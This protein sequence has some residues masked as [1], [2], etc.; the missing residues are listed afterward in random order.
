MENTIKEYYIKILDLYN[1]CVNMLTA[2][3]Q[4]LS[5]SS[6]QVVVNISDGTGSSSTMKI[7]SFIY[8]ENKLEELQGNFENFFDIPKSGD[9]W[10]ENDSNM[11]KFK[12]V[13]ANIAPQTPTISTDNLVSSFT[14]NNYF[15][16]L[17][18]PKM[19]LKMNVQNLTNNIEEIFVKKYIFYN[20]SLYN[21][22]KN[23]NSKTNEEYSAILYSFKKGIDY[24]V[25]DSTVQLPL[26]KEVYNSN[27]KIT[28]I[29][30][31]EGQNPWIQSTDGNDYANYQLTLNTLEYYN[32]EDSSIR[33]ILKPGDYIC[34]NDT[35][36]QYR[37]KSVNTTTNQVIIEERIGHTSLQTYDEN[38]TMFFTIYS[39]NF[40]EY[41]Y[42]QVP[43]EENQYI[44][45][46]IG[47]IYNNI[48]S[49]LSE[50]V[51]L[52]MKE[53]HM[54]DENG[55]S[56]LDENG[57]PINYIDYYNAY[58]KNIGDILTGFS[59]VSNPLLSEFDYTF[60]NN[61]QTDDS[62]KEL[63]NNTF[64]NNDILQVVPINKH[65]IDDTTSQEIISMHNQKSELNNKLTSINSNIDELYNTLTNTDWSQ[66]VTN[67]QLAIRKKLDEYYTER[68][69]ITTQINNI[70]DTIN[71][72]S[73]VKYQE[74]LKYRIRGVLYTTQLETYVRTL[75]NHNVEIIGMEVWYK[76]KSNYSTTTSLSTISTNTFTDWNEYKTNDKQ[77]YID[78]NN[79]K[80]SID[81]KWETPSNTDNVIKWNQVDIPITQN[82]EVIVKVRYKYNIGQPFLTLYTPWS[83][84]MTITFPDE[85]KELVEIGDI[86]SKNQDDTIK[87]AFSKTLI[88]DG[89][90]EHVNNK[91]ISNS[92]TF[93]H[94]PE[95]IYSGF[96]TSE[97]NL[98]SLKDKLTEM[99][100]NINKYLELL[101]QSMNK[102]YSVYL[103]LDNQL[104]EIFS[105]SVN[106]ININDTSISD[107]FVKKYMRIIIKNS[108][109]APVKLYS[110]FPGNIDVALIED[111]SEAYSKYIGNYERVPLLV[112]NQMSAQTL[113]QWIYFR[114]NNPYTNEDI[115]LNEENQRLQDKANIGG[116]LIWEQN[117]INYIRQNNS[118]IL[119]PYKDHGTIKINVT[120]NIWQTLEWNGAY[121]TYKGVN[122]TK[123]DENS[124]EYTNKT[125][126]NFYH[127][128]NVGDGTNNYLMRFEDIKYSDG[129][130]VICLTENDNI[131]DF[132]QD[133]ADYLLGSVTNYNGAFFFPDI[134]HRNNICISGIESN[135]TTSEII[136]VG[137][138]ISIPVT[139]EYCLS[140]TT[141]SDSSISTIKKSL[142][143]DLKDSLF[144]DPKSFMIEITV[145]NNYSSL[146][147]YV[148]NLNMLTPEA[149]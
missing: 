56:L 63:V 49:V 5:T 102:Q 59:E 75:A 18:S 58:A 50:G 147:N 1:N 60:L 62:I 89:Y 69:Q 28:S 124:L 39:G 126:E 112:N 17:V 121:L 135:P 15:K 72:K 57:N 40:D 52:N 13:K 91:F 22:I 116:N 73:I 109:D 66:E 82:E 4:S 95:N 7:P 111:N 136:E 9:T 41:N 90:A 92:Q 134:I 123:D 145:N 97:N 8:L 99:N 104:F 100:T 30:S 64:N 51:L 96:N 125:L 76:Y 120:K 77:R 12:L 79:L 26:K 87:S 31:L 27:F 74:D 48:R 43:L 105:G 128:T 115:Y 67:S 6:P 149:E 142:Y 117:Y 119:L 23:T 21:I 36:T 130:K 113:G 47:T 54:V 133:G 127:Y 81:V 106:R 38:D 53:I 88:N 3:N 114:Q 139:F 101:N 110:Q 29:P 122:S 84:E 42:I 103:E 131:N 93:Y 25:Y 11:Y 146:N 14:D 78:F 132:N 19:Y 37:V 16:D 141:S 144:M 32:Q 10:F 140:N 138:E 137:K 33:F 86:V 94:M 55:Q 46:F 118:Q 148:G 65:I 107:S 129:H 35:N 44:A 20:E 108:G 24:D 143:F 71:S 2:L 85:Y 45:L 68:T 83:D 80:S 98:L 34:L 61:L 70:V